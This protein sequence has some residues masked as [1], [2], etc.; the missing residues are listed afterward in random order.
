MKFLWGLLVG[1]FLG[2]IGTMWYVN[3]RMEA[4]DV[5]TAV[6]AAIN[7]ETV[8]VSD[9]SALPTDFRIFYADFHQDSVFQL[10]HVS[11]P[12]EGLPAYADSIQMIPGN[13]KYKREDWS[14]HRGF[15]DN[16][17]QFE[18]KFNILSEN[19][20]IET[21]KDDQNGIG[22]QR[23]FANSDGEWRLI[24]YADINLMR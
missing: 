15:N 2:A 4:S 18:R 20:I 1:A 23:R 24:Y 22:M 6:N 8:I 5:E 16:E 12:L 14:L 10:E 21:I 17:G 9:E 13:Y 7:T 3:K 11:F 19:M